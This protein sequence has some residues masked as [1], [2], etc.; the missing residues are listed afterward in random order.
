M[1]NPVYEK[2]WYHGFGLGLAF[3]AIFTH[4][5][6]AILGAF[7]NIDWPTVAITVTPGLA[8]VAVWQ[9]S[10]IKRW[11]RDWRRY[12]AEA[13]AEQEMDRKLHPR[14]PNKPL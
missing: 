3:G 4:D 7:T 10:E 8:L 6:H 1:P 5:P 2:G 13:K 14:H 9:R 12:Q 11:Y